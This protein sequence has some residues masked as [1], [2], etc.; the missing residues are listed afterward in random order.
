MAVQCRQALP[1][2]LV[3]AVELCPTAIP[4]P[5]PS[6]PE[7]RIVYVRWLRGETI[8]LAANRRPRLVIRAILMCLQCTHC[9]LKYTP[10][11]TVIQHKIDAGRVYIGF[12][13]DRP[14]IEWAPCGFHRITG[15]IL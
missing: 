7:N 9:N 8:D 2:G 1:G 5:L 6:A 4:Q 11:R 10:F 3:N 15:E 12:K 13:A 14:G